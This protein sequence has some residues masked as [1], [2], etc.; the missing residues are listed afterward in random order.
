MDYIEIM[1]RDKELELID[2]AGP[3]SKLGPYDCDFNDMLRVLHV[4]RLFTIH[5]L[6]ARL[7]EQLWYAIENQRRRGG[8]EAKGGG[9]LKRPALFVL[10]DLHVFC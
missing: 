9:L 1:P 5:P 8:R 4:L 6:T 2:V 7:A 10:I 3:E